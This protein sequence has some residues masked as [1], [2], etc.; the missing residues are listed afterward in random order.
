M[1]LKR[2]VQRELV[3]ELVCYFGHPKE[4]LTGKKQKQIKYTVKLKHMQET[5][6]REA[7]FYT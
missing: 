1:S 4:K 3:V 5:N 2:S 6:F 7:L